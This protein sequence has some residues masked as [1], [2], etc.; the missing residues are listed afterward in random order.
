MA[1][2]MIAGETLRWRT[3][4][5][6]ILGVGGIGLINAADLSQIHPKAPMVA[7]VMIISPIVVALSSIVTKRNLT[8]YPHLAFSALPMAYAALFHTG[9]WLVFER[10]RALDWD[11]QGIV[12]LLYLTIPGTV[13]TFA[14]YNWL[15][16]KVEV[17]RLNLTA[18]L[19]PLI[20]LFVGTH[21]GKEP[22]TPKMLAGV[23][24]VLVGIAVANQR[25]RVTSGVAR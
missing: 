6:L 21:V 17:S 13:V 15:L 2:W 8:R 24:L 11:T 25:R 12:A 14:A 9:V 22:L 18:Y 10:H 5:G 16:T 1:H 4:A 19:T 7:S 20:A 3:V 23:V